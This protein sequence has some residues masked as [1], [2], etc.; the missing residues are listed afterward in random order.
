MPNGSSAK[1]RQREEY[2]R[3][4][5]ERQ[6]R[7]EA[8]MSSNLSPERAFRLVTKRVAWLNDKI[9]WA[10][11]NGHRSTLYVEEREALLWMMDKIKELCERLLSV[12]PTHTLNGGKDNEL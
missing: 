4:S 6:A 2:T 7:R 11:A 3:T 8:R 9:A 1:Q 5:L 10:Q 12:S